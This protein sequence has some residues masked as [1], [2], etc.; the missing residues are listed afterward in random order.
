MGE[1]FCGGEISLP[2]FLFQICNTRRAKRASRFGVKQTAAF[3]MTRLRIIP[4]PF[5]MSSTIVV[6]AFKF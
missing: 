5:I 3:L 4:H 1:K 2:H 6:T